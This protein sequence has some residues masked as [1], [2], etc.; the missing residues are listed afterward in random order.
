MVFTSISLERLLAVGFGIAA[1]QDLVSF[2]ILWSKEA[3][4]NSFLLMFSSEGLMFVVFAFCLSHAK[5]M[6]YHSSQPFSNFN[7]CSL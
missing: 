5:V 6:K 4:F 1:M 3:M 2:F 7:H